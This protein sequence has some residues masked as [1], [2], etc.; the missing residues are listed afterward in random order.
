VS[1]PVPPPL[2]VGDIVEI[3]GSVYAGERATVTAVPEVMYRDDPGPRVWLEIVRPEKVPFAPLV[4]QVRRVDPVPTPEGDLRTRIERAIVAEDLQSDTR[5]RREPGYCGVTARAD[6]VLAEVEPEL[7]RLRAEADEWKR[8][9][10][11]QSQGR[12]AEVASLVRDLHAAQF[13]GSTSLPDRPLDTVWN[14]LLDLVRKDRSRLSGGN[15]PAD[16]R[17]VRA[18][19]AELRI[20]EENVEFCEKV[21]HLVLQCCDGQQD[22]CPAL[23][24][25]YGAVRGGH[26]PP[27]A[28]A[29]VLPENWRDQIGWLLDVRQGEVLTKVTRLIE[30]WRGER[31]GTG[32]DSSPGWGSAV[33][34]PEVK[35]TPCE[36]CGSG[37]CPG[38]RDG[39]ESCRINPAVATPDDTPAGREHPPGARPVTYIHD[40]RGWTLTCVLCPW[41]ETVAT[42]KE[43]ERWAELH[44]HVCPASP[45]GDTE[46]QQD[47]APR[48]VVQHRAET[49]EVLPGI[50]LTTCHG[51]DLAISGT[52]DEAQDAADEHIADTLQIAKED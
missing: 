42:A 29:V 48:E 27:I 24:A 17:E 20:E 36:W 35:D 1:G 43:A 32:D 51:C 34:T 12:S 8:A 52:H 15:T 14:W 28:D 33:A 2:A 31:S 16:A 11:A 6:A 22:S 13:D 44:E 18:L 10:E 9:A 49:R 41:T 26:R 37:R 39:F 5:A 47:A 40:S 21:L 50:W 23:D 4:D 19:R 25:V 46:A 7:A 38:A 3:T 30:M 45:V